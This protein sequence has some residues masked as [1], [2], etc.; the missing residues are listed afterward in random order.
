MT[1]NR[2]P[3]VKKCKVTHAEET[4]NIQ[5]MPGV[6]SSFV[7]QRVSD[8]EEHAAS[9]AIYYNM[10]IPRNLSYLYCGVVEEFCEFKAVI[11]ELD[12]EFSSTSR[13]NGQWVVP[14]KTNISNGHDTDKSLV[15][16]GCLEW[17]LK[18]LK[19]LGDVVWYLTAMCKELDM[20]LESVVEI[21][22]DLKIRNPSRSHVK[23]M[24]PNN[25][26]AD[27]EILISK[28]L[29]D[30]L[31][32]IGTIGGKIKK[33]IRDDNETVNEEKRCIIL[34]KIRGIF[35]IISNQVC[36]WL[37]SSLLYVMQ[38]NISKI[39]SRFERGVIKGDGD[40]R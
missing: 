24:H 18:S 38:L 4:L 35:S 17:R 27:A 36:P 3:A 11:E 40:D 31:D 29:S 5:E 22:N 14:G 30:M 6:T 10:S 8:Y 20:K 25:L 21:E 13:V 1:S 39:K 28:S 23:E 15:V 19:E 33:S 2:D 9:T 26:N 7:V 34:E 12:G 32:N 37:G 16:S